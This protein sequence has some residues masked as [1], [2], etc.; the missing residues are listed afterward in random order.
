[1]EALEKK[2]VEITGKEQAVFM[3]SG[4]MANQ[5]AIATLSGSKSKVFVQDESHVFRDEADAAQTVF[6][7]RLIGL[8]KG[9]PY[10][11]AAQL[12]NAVESLPRDEVFATGIG[13]VSIENPVRRMNGRMVP[14][15]ELKTISA[16]CR[17]QKIPVH[18]DGARIYMAA[19]WSG[20]SI[21][22]YASL[23]DTFYI[24]LYKY[25]G[26]SAGAILCGDKNLI[27]QMPHLIKIHGGSMYGNWTNAAMALFRLEGLEARMKDV[28]SRSADLFAKLNKLDGIK[29]NALE[30]GTNIFQMTLD[31]KINGAKM[32]ERMRTEFNIQFQKPNEKN[33]SLLT[34]N[35]TM[36][37]QDNEYLVN[38]FRETMG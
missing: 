18:I 30:G 29:I 1:V 17:E 25:L 19:A 3:P 12:Q 7:K 27:G 28:V 10:F 26:A 16:Y 2:F 5:L 20:K 13:A 21:K 32:H 9:E 37:Y 11:T 14:F 24:S 15:E 31:P 36:L 33:Q 22:D 4:T 34:V 35:E 23:A 8:A 38:A 6:N